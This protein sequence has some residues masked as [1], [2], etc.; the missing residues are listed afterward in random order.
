LIAGSTLLTESIPIEDRP[1][2]QGATD[3]LMG[4]AGASAGLLSGVVVGFGSYGLLAIISAL[5]VGVL[6]TA[7]L[8]P[9]VLRL[10][11]A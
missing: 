9:S 6:V 4:I 8:R 3:L 1:E 7:V 2:A 5:L 10:G 11:T